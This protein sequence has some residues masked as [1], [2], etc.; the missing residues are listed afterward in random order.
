MAN[1]S[2]AYYMMSNGYDPH[3]ALLIQRLLAAQ[4]A[5]RGLQ[6]TPSQVS[7]A[8]ML[9]GHFF[10]ANVQEQ[11]QSTRPTMIR[12][13]SVIDTAP[14]YGMLRCMVR[15]N[16]ERTNI[17]RERLVLQ[18][19]AHHERTAR[20]MA[21]RASQQE[22]VIQPNSAPKISEHCNFISRIH[23]DA[24]ITGQRHYRMAHV[25]LAKGTSKD[26]IKAPKEKPSKPKRDTK[27]LAS[28]EEILQY[29]DE[30]GDCIVPRGFPLNPR[31]ASWV[32]EQRKQYKLLQDGKNSS[33]T[34][35][36]IELLNKIGFAWNAQE[37]AW[38]KHITDLK[39]FKEE[40]GD[41][42]VPLNHPKYPKLGLWV[43]EQ[44]RH[45][46]L[47]KQEKPSHMT[48]ERARALDAVGFCWDTHEAVWG[49]RLREL[50]E[51][52]A[53]FGD[54]IVPTNFPANPKLGTWVHHQR[55]QYKK[56]KEGKSCHIT[57]E[58]VR[59]LEAIGFVW[60]PRERTRRFSEAT[61]SDQDS[62]TES[63]SDDAE[64]KVGVRPKKRRRSHG[65]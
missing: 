63:E 22:R 31:L 61:S 54:C 58:R 37:A 4:Q 46:T 40:Y 35:R 60:Y 21:D 57:D 1:Y 30:Y 18:E 26:K 27:W 49:E 65:M 53:Q 51:Y 59:A 7:G 6:N 20:S 25:E 16:D 43:K 12:F 5:Q 48:E 47:M 15:M 56:H 9:L 62:D 24:G 52:K 36:R 28:Y 32:A 34:P 11:Y 3:R 14:D 10:G 39:A 13:A 42:L 17:N 33:I 41:C 64:D 45:Y 2:P 8:N 19:M 38:E 55:R 50:C 23:Q 29:K 44:R